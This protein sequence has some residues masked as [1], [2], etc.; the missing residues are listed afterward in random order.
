MKCIKPFS[1]SEIYRSFWR[2]MYKPIKC[3]KCGT[4]HRIAIS[5][6]LTF[7]SVTILPMSIFVNFLSPFDSFLSTL[8]VGIAILIISSLVTP[9]LVKFKV[10]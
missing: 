10:K 6:R 1:W 3:D 9:Y 7:V 4:E 8:G 5:G 2:W